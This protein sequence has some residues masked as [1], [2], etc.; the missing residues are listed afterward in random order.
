MTLRY[1]LYFLLIIACSLWFT[2]FT[3]AKDGSQGSQHLKLVQV[4]DTPKA[5]TTALIFDAQIYQPTP[6][7][8]FER[9]KDL[10]MGTLILMSGY[11]KD[12]DAGV[13]L[14]QI[15]REKQFNTRVGRIGVQI[16]PNTGF[17]KTKGVCLSACAMAFSGGVKRQID[18]EDRIGVTSIEPTK[19]NLT[20]QQYKQ[21]VD[22]T[23]AYLQKMGINKSFFEFILDLKGDAIQIIDYPST[24]KYG[25]N[26]NPKI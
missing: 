21:A 7:E 19:K 1:A 22:A 5:C 26:N 17:Y 9:V 16:S 12:L 15:I 8:F 18:S 4:C 20:E 13:K 11:G 25:L 3:H 24:I 10:P 23:A 6:K 2:P 14:G